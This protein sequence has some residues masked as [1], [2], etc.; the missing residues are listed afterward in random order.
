MADADPL[1]AELLDALQAGGCALCRLGRRAG[2]RYLKMLNDEGVNDPGLRRALQEAQGLCH[3]HAWQWTQRRGSP[4][5][6]AIVYRHLLGDLTAALEK[7]A[8]TRINVRRKPQNIPT[9]L[10]PCPV[11]T[12]ENEAVTRYG[13]TILARLAHPDLATAYD[14]AGGLCLPHL[15]HLLALADDAQARTLL[16]WQTAIY[17][18][19][20]AQLD[21]FIRKHDHRFRHEPFAAEKDA[22][23]RAVAAL[24]G[25]ADSG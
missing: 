10:A 7:Q 5:G 15:R 14:A 12:A 3:R 20:L 24:T 19:L 21:E 25:E 23:T 22:W 11:C 17:R 4:L 8:Q 16:S 2:S 13:Q 1:Y 18:R 6:V 9:G